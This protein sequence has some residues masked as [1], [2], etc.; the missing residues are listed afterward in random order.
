M[1]LNIYQFL[2]SKDLNFSSFYALLIVIFD[3]SN[4]TIITSV[5]NRLKIILEQKYAN[6]DEVMPN[7]LEDKRFDAI[8]DIVNEEIARFLRSLL[9]SYCSFLLLNEYKLSREKTGNI[10]F[11]FLLF[12]SYLIYY[13]N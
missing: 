8:R 11:Y 3:S 2:P 5:K 12:R 10:F 1:L 13:I 9:D 4:H 6:I 7:Q